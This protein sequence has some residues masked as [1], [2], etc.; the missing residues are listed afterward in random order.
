VGIGNARGWSES[1]IFFRQF[2]ERVASLAAGGCEAGG[3]FVSDCV[4]GFP[5]ATPQFS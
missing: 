3:D 4:Q 2:E 1:Q 5:V